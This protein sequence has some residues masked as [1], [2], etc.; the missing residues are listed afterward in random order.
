MSDTQTS[1]PARV[2]AALRRQQAAQAPLAVVSKM[3]RHSKISMTVD[4][5]GRLSRKIS[6]AAADTYGAAATTT[7]P[8]QT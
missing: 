3:L 4:L 6:T 1:S 7:R 5:H 8:Q 2:V